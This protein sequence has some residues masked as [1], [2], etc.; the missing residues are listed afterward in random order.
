MSDL[1]LYDYPISG[2]CYKVRLLLAQLGLP[3]HRV[4]VD[5]KMG[6]SLSPELQR[7]NPRGQIPLLV[8]GDEVIWDSMA[9]LVYLAR[10]YGDEAWLPRD[11]LEEARV[12]Q[13]LAVAGNE[14]LFGL[15]RARA[16]FL[17]GRAFDLEQCQRDAQIGLAALEVRLGEADWLACDHPTIA[18]L[19]CYPYVML[20]P[21]GKVSLD[22][23]PAVR[24]WMTRLEALPG[25]VAMDA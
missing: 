16:V 23:Y 18:D 17:L 19:A 10:R 4:T 24:G 21:Q 1:T 12:M 14:L 9:I 6:E 8:D 2:N 5:I 15:A 20:A 11:A 7:L 22:T 3:Y 13:W 25:W